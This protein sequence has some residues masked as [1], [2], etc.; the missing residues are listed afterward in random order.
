[1]IIG[2]LVGGVL[3]GQE[4]IKQAQIRSFI[5]QLSGYDAAVNTFRAKYRELPGDM[6]KAVTFGL[7]A[8]ETSLTE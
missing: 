6:T 4:L 3:Q 2:L 8:G 7:N 5:S 1:V